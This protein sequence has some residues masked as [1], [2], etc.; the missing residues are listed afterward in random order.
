MSV[1]GVFMTQSGVQGYL[2][3]AVSTGVKSG[4]NSMQRTASGSFLPADAEKT[5][6]A[7]ACNPI[8]DEELAVSQARRAAFCGRYKTYILAGIAIV[9]LG[10]W[11]SSTILKATRHRW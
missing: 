9:I 11:I 1:S 4:E 10:W 8:A 7:S 2:Q 3:P 5:T 6:G